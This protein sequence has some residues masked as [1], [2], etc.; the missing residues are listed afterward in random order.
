MAGRGRRQDRR[1]G[2]VRHLVATA[3]E[4]PRLRHAAQQP[5][6]GGERRAGGDPRRRDA[7][8]QGGG[9]AVRRSEEGDSQGMSPQAQPFRQTATTYRQGSLTLSREYYTAPAI[10]EEENERLFA[11]QWN[12]VGRS[13]RIAQAG[14]WF[15][16]T[17][18]GDSLIVLRDRQGALR[19]FFN[20]CRHRG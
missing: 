10:L 19:A 1:A 16:A 17:V 4:E 5:D 7:L 14:A 20:V 11:T 18:A 3:Q 2:D 13:S 6:G 15:L 8:R 9:E 12:C